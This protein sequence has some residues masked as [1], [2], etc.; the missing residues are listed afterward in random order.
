MILSAAFKEFGKNKLIQQNQNSARV[1]LKNL[2]AARS[3]IACFCSNYEN[4]AV[5]FIQNF[6]AISLPQVHATRKKHAYLSST[7]GSVTCAI[8]IETFF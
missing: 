8:S 1:L 2:T 3:L 6:A 4:K 7:T 5:L